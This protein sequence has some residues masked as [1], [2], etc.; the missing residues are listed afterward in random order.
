MVDK[1]IELSPEDV[2]W[3]NIDVRVPY[4]CYFSELTAP[5]LEHCYRNPRALD[6]ELDR[7]TGFDHSV[8]IPRRFYGNFEQY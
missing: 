4:R 1:W 3:D 2:V 7:N 8:V 6:R 5:F